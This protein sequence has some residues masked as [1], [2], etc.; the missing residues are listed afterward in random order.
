MTRPLLFSGAAGSAGSNPVCRRTAVFIHLIWL[1]TFAINGPPQSAL[2]QSVLPLD[3]ELVATIQKAQSLLGQQKYSQAE[4]LL[5]AATLKYENKPGPWYL[6]G[7]ALHGQKKLDAALAMYEKSKS[8]PQTRI[9]SLYNIACIYSLQNQPDKVFTALESAISAGFNNF[10]QLQGDSDFDNVKADPR[11][12]KLI[13]QWLPDDQIFVEPTRIIHQWI[14]EAANDQFGWTARR[15]GDLDG[16]GKIDL[17][18]TAPT[19]NSGAGRIYVYSSATGKQ[20]HTV[21][22]KPGQR[23]GNSATGIGDVNG[24]GIPDFVAGAPAADGKGAAFVYSGKDASVIHSIQGTTTGGQF[25]Y[26]V[27]ETGDIDGDDVPDFFVGEMAGQGAE[28]TSGRGSIYSG[29]TAQPIL[30]L[31]GERAGDGFG[32]AAAVAKIA[33]REFLLAIG[34]PN[35]GPAKRGRV[36]VYQIR[37]STPRLRF[38]IEGDVNSVNLGQMFI[39]FPGDVDRDGVPDVYASDFSDNTK[40]PGGG[41]IVVHSGADGRELIVIHGTVAGEGM[42][43]SPSDAGDVDGDGIGDLVIGAWQNKEGSPSGG[44]VYLYSLADKGTLLRTWTCKQAGDTLGFDAC[45]I[46]DVDGDGQI[47]F[48]LTSA[49]SNAKGPKTGRVFIVAGGDYSA[50]PP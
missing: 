44:K 4:V 25:G 3:P 21:V 31:D 26:E 1:M 41:K 42:G 22:G 48:L 12:E 11:F 14:G 47:D 34:A 27:S 35:A 16:D 23:L 40:A 49:W 50:E 36:Y 38:T 13:P 43:T 6:L 39:A 17:I 29:K 10:A 5:R 37:N 2:G 45:G 20:L 32:N 30:E 24:D 9:N 15:V 46:G 33:D 19:H 7:N 8:Y 28:P 18:A